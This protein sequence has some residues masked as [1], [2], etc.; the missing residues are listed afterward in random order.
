MHLLEHDD[1]SVLDY[2]DLFVREED[3][4]ESVH[5]DEPD[6]RRRT[7]RGYPLKESYLQLLCDSE[8][9]E[10]QSYQNVIDVDIKH[11][12]K[13]LPVKPPRKTRFDQLDRRGTS[14]SDRGRRMREIVRSKMRWDSRLAIFGAGDRGRHSGS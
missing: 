7:S 13:G 14:A 5:F 8:H 12:V 9:S 2:Q 10:S 3:D 1:T 4:D 6:Q 11:V